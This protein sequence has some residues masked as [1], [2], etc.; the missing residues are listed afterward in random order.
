MKLSCPHLLLNYIALVNMMT[1]CPEI[2]H[3]FHTRLTGTNE[4]STFGVNAILNWL[5][6][7]LSKSEGET[8]IHY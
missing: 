4:H 1:F 2:I 5:K 7:M 3:E 6:H 8:V